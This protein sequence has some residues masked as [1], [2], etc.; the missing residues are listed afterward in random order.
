M[1]PHLR[2]S[3]TPVNVLAVLLPLV[4]CHSTTSKKKPTLEKS[5]PYDLCSKVHGFDSRRM[6]EC[7]L[8]YGML[9]T[10]PRNIC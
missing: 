6:S 9:L 3:R 1:Y 5:V 7:I 10:F 2:A 8:S 4:F